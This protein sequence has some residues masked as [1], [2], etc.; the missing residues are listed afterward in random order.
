[1]TESYVGITIRTEV[2][3]QDGITVDMET[4]EKIAIEATACYYKSRHE[5]CP[6]VRIERVFP[7]HLGIE[8]YGVKPQT[9]LRITISREPE[10]YA[11]F[12]C[13][14]E[15]DHPNSNE[16]VLMMDLAQKLSA[17]FSDLTF[18]VGSSLFSHPDCAEDEKYTIQ[19]KNGMLIDRLTRQE[20]VK[21]YLHKKLP[22]PGA[23]YSSLRGKY[24][25]LR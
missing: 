5:T 22:R 20:W 3:D 18:N 13:W 8:E 6:E 2:L 17:R 21:R 24:P 7:V 23:E 9:D 19:F 1:V 14:M 4:L 16:W 12:N 10:N 25:H 11:P 15:V